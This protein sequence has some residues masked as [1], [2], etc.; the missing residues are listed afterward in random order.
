[1]KDLRAIYGA[2]L[3][4]IECMA[5]TNSDSIRFRREHLEFVDVDRVR[6]LGNIQADMA[7]LHRGESDV[8]G[9]ADGHA[10]CHFLP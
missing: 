7:R 9:G 10:T 2:A 8:L 1:M 4:R 6:G 3:D 5:I